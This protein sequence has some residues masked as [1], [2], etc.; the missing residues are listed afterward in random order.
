MKCPRILKVVVKVQTQLVASV[1]AMPPKKCHA[2]IQKYNPEWL[3]AQH[4]TAHTLVSAKA[5]SAAL[6][7]TVIN[8]TCQQFWCIYFHY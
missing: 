5:E 4:H 6:F 3:S 1:Q 2:G 8:V 7:S